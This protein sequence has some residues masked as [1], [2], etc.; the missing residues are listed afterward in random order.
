MPAHYSLDTRVRQSGEQAI[1]LSWSYGAHRYQNTIGFSVKKAHWD[2]H[3][4]RVVPHTHNADGVSAEAINAYLNKLYGVSVTLDRAAK[5]RQ[6]TLTRAIMQGALS[7]ALS[8]NYTSAQVIADKWVSLHPLQGQVLGR[9]KRTAAPTDV[10][11][12]IVQPQ[13]VTYYRFHKGGYY[14]KVCKAHYATLKADL[15]ILQEL[16]GL[17]RFIAVTPSD[18]YVSHTNGGELFAYYMEVSEKEALGRG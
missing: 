14:R 10:K 5:E 13:P 16:F 9:K 15:I 8:N 17:N 6:V 7:D 2:A 4:R 11:P 1:R 3:K 12:T 18:F